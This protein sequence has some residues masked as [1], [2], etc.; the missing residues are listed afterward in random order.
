MQNIGTDDS[1]SMNRK[2]LQL[3][4]VCI[5]IDC[6]TVCNVFVK[7]YCTR[8]CMNW[9]KNL[10][11]ENCTSFLYKFLVLYPNTADTSSRGLY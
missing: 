3:H 6:I 2:L 11:Q 4:I 5:C 7:V 10:V 9:H 8:T 1:T